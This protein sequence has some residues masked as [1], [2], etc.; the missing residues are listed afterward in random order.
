MRI[1]IRNEISRS[2]LQKLEQ[3]KQ[4]DRQTDR[5]MRRNAFAGGTKLTVTI[6]QVL[7]LVMHDVWNDSFQT[8]CTLVIRKYHKI[9]VYSP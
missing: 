5:H 4:T 1:Y 2:R 6:L 9:H 3:Y 8:T 7:M